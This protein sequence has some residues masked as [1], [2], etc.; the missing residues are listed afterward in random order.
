MK[1]CVS[2]TINK[3]NVEAVTTLKEQCQ[4]IHWSEYR[5]NTDIL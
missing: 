4:N 1:E 5:Q 2:Y 3:K